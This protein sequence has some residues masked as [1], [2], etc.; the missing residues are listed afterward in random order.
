MTWSYHKG[1]G[2][3]YR[4]P[5]GRLFEMNNGLYFLESGD[6]ARWTSDNGLLLTREEFI[7]QFVNKRSALILWANAKRKKRLDPNKRGQKV[8]PVTGNYF[9]FADFESEYSNAAHIL[10]SCSPRIPKKNPWEHDRCRALRDWRQM[11][12]RAV[13]WFR[14]C[15]M[16]R[17]FTGSLEEILFHCVRTRTRQRDGEQETTWTYDKTDYLRIPHLPSEINQEEN[18][19]TRVLARYDTDGNLYTKTDFALYYSEPIGLLLWSWAEYAPASEKYQDPFTNAWQTTMT[20]PELYYK[21][22]VDLVQ[23]VQNSRATSSVEYRTLT[24]KKNDSGETQKFETKK[25]THPS[26]ITSLAGVEENWRD[27]LLRNWEEINDKQL[28]KVLICGDARSENVPEVYF[29]HGLYFQRY[30]QVKNVVAKTTDLKPK[31]FWST[32]SFTVTKYW[33]GICTEWEDWSL[34]RTLS[35]MAKNPDQVYQEYTEVFKVMDERVLEDQKCKAKLIMHITRHPDLTE[36]EKEGEV[37]WI[38]NSVW[39][40]RSEELKAETEK[41]DRCAFIDPKIGWRRSIDSEKHDGRQG[42]DKVFLITDPEVQKIHGKHWTV[43]LP[44]RKS[45]QELNKDP[46]INEYN[47]FEIYYHHRICYGAA[48][49][50]V[51]IV[52]SWGNQEFEEFCGEAKTKIQWF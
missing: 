11:K 19:E 30:Y 52:R 28:A 12:S 29:L 24:W 39:Q 48:G 23:Q 1:P 47:E 43:R 51:S 7:K 3:M 5:E 10:W 50:R 25:D 35:F 31:D 15:L 36:K 21:Y 9:T 27:I 13:C 17:D 8:D 34:E 6:E 20:L 44:R 40:Y 26:K 4:C 16:A 33:C 2:G 22:G 38:T 37:K 49:P 42:P 46:R 14:E 45:Y 18:G 41:I 32:E